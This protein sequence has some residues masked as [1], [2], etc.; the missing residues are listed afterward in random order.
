MLELTKEDLEEYSAVL[1]IPNEIEG[2]IN[3]EEAHE[4]FLIEVPW[5]DISKE[6]EIISSEDWIFF[7]IAALNTN[8]GFVDRNSGKVTVLGTGG[9]VQLKIWSYTKGY[10]EDIQEAE[11]TILE[12]YDSDAVYECFKK[13]MGNTHRLNFKQNQI[14]FPITFK[15]EPLKFSLFSIYKCEKQRLAKIKVKH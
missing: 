14:D 6:E 3:F 10:L 12:C 8:G 4:L 15:V 7:R 1:G 11:I 2:K 13:E 9:S 5:Y